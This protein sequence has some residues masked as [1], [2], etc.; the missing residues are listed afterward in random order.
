MTKGDHMTGYLKESHVRLKEVLFNDFLK[1]GRT[2]N[3]QGQG[4]PK[5]SSLYSEGFRV[6]IRVM[7]INF[8]YVVDMLFVGQ[9]W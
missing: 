6:E 4:V 2:S 7:R 9:W 1:K 3:P 8:K 5:S